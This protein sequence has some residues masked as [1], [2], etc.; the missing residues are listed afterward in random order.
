MVR[1][2]RRR[3]HSREYTLAYGMGMQYTQALDLKNEWLDLPDFIREGKSFTMY[4]EGL[5]DAK[6][7]A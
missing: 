7:A 1:Y 3:L 6:K 4:L 2:G 5:I